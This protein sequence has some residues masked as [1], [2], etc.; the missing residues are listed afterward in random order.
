MLRVGREGGQAQIP[1]S[2]RNTWD[3]CQ[4]FNALEASGGS[5]GEESA[6]NAGDPGSIPGSGRSPGVGNGNLVFLPGEFHEQRSL[7]GYS[8]WGCK[9]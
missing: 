7:T 2:E 4:K 1:V 6:C 8:P 3:P 9:E 5:D